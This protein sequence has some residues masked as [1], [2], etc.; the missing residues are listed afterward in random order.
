MFK[1]LYIVLVF[2]VVTGILVTGAPSQSSYPQP[3]LIIGFAE[4]VFQFTNRN[5][6]DYNNY[7][8][9]FENST[10]FLFFCVL[11]ALIFRCGSGNKGETV[12][13]GVD[14]CCK[15][16]DGCYKDWDSLASYYIIDANWMCANSPSSD[17]YK[18]C[19]CDKEAAQCFARN[20]YH[21][22]LKGRCDNQ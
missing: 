3:R 13:D 21:E 1:R 15:I 9:W 2:V 6:L 14:M 18:A 19:M 17:Q 5:P 22:Y 8:C 20:T 10:L 11:F 12:M 16:H 4:F 7:G